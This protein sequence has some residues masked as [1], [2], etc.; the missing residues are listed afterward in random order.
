MEYLARKLLTDYNISNNNTPS[1][2]TEGGTTII[3]DND[4]IVEVIKDLKVVI[5][6]ATDFLGRK[7]ERSQ[8]VE[9]KQATN[10]NNTLNTRYK[11]RQHGKR[12]Y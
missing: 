2:T 3:N 11:E 8:Q 5:K 4:D 1:L 7:L 9:I 10:I 6:Q 12:S